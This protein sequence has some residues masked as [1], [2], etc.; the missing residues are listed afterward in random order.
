[1][2][3]SQKNLKAYILKGWKQNHGLFNPTI[4]LPFVKVF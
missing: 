2:K 4:Y 3:N 1:M